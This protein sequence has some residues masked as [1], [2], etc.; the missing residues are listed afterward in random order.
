[1]RFNIQILEIL[2]FFKD[3]YS[4]NYAKINL[5]YIHQIKFYSPSF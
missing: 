1:M 2:S 3:F 4:N 5:L